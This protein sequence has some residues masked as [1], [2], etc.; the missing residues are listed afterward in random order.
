MW[1]F[2]VRLVAIRWWFV[3]ILLHSELTFLIFGDLFNIFWHFVVSRGSVTIILVIVKTIFSLSAFI[4][5]LN[6]YLR[7]VDF[8]ALQIPA[9][10]QQDLLTCSATLH[11][12]SVYSFRNFFP[13]ASILIP[14]ASNEL[15]EW[16]IEYTVFSMG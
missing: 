3:Q 4:N 6:Y 15:G 11:K 2:F 9:F 12:I 16:V 10:K 14:R 1:R 13:S 8:N 5:V 7:L